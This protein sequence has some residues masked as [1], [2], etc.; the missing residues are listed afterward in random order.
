MMN[1][2]CE[3]Q[4]EEPQRSQVNRSRLAARDDQPRLRIVN[5]ALCIRIA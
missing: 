2:K 1:A 5:F 4:N 3:M